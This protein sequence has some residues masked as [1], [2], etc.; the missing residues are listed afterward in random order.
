MRQ[1]VL[2]REQWQFCYSAMQEYKDSC[3][4]RS[5][6]VAHDDLHIG[7]VLV[8]DETKQRTGFLDFG[9]IRKVQ[10]EALFLQW[11]HAWPV[12]CVEA[13]VER[14]S[15]EQKEGL[16]MRDV[17]LFELC[18]KLLYPE[19]GMDMFADE[20]DISVLYEG[21]GRA[22]RKLGSYPESSNKKKR[23]PAKAAPVS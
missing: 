8:D 12:D 15:S 14:Y 2:S 7:N 1:D 19:S 17:Y 21:I 5:A 10:P 13:A 22:Y 11:L 20:Y 6:I 18:G 16:S 4:K 3:A 9:F 23:V